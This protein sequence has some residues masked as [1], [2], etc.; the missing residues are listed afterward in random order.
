M[1]S[2][3]LLTLAL[4]LLFSLQALAQTISPQLE[5]RAALL[6]SQA[7]QS[8]LGYSI[9]ESLTT[10]VGP[11]LAGTEAE[12]RAR[13]WAVAKFESMGF[14]NV[15]V[16]TFALPV[17]ERGVEWAQI[18]APY[19]QPLVVTAL[20]GSISTGPD[21][22][23]GE[24]ASFPSLNALAIAPAETVKGKII[25]VDEVMTRTQDGSG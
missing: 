18:T 20:G 2:R 8:N 23:E 5:A 7:E 21:G 9:V 25:L 13:N 14:A 19:P 12:E 16:E 22:V 1:F 11:R 3:R 24:L 10:E 15:R 6:A 17:W 4:T